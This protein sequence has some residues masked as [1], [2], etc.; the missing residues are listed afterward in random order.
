M[1]DLWKEL[2][3]RALNHKGGDDSAYLLA[4]AKRIP[5]FTTGCACR[6]HWRT[7][8]SQNRPGFVVTANKNEYFEWT[9]KMHNEI[10]KKINKPQYT[11]EQA[12]SFYS[13]QK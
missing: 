3:L 8:Y 1:A 13:A 12:K 11:V 4:F 7:I 9:V 10:N 6:E 5:R 2:H